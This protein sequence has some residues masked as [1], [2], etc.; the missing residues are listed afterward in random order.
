MPESL[1][2][3][4][5]FL[6]ACAWRT[7]TQWGFLYRGLGVHKVFKASPKGKRPAW[8]SI[9]HVGSGH[10]VAILQGDIVEVFGVATELAE[11]GEWDF[12]GL[13]GWR[14]VDP[15]LMIKV[16][17]ILDHLPKSVKNI[18]TRGEASEERAREIAEARA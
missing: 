5:E 1:W 4:G 16:R 10:H 13:S 14:N 6:V 11:C 18:G 12:D 17:H 8:W 9:I 2:K 7:E 15:E 3:Q